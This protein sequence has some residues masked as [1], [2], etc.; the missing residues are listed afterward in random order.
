MKHANFVFLTITLL[1]LE[2]YALDPHQKCTK[3]DQN[4][5]RDCVLHCEYKYY[6]FADDQFNINKAHRNVLRNVLLKYHVITNDQVEKIDEHLEKCAKEANPKAQSAEKDKCRRVLKYSLC[7]VNDSKLFTY[8][9][10]MKALIRFGHTFN[11]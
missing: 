3:S 5:S 9:T 8:N 7:V 10:Y 6:G 11:L 1:V 4:I 2:I